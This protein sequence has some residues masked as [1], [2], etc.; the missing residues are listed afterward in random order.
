MMILNFIPRFGSA[1][2]GE[3]ATSHSKADQILARSGRRSLMKQKKAKEY[4]GEV[5]SCVDFDV[6]SL[7]ASLAAGHTLI[8]TDNQLAL[9]E[10][11]LV[12][13][14]GFLRFSGGTH[15]HSSPTS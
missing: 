2:T 13:T 6:L 5:L 10:L 8:Q 4:C 12:K 15:F 11:L 7:G 9:L 1:K 3:K 14:Q